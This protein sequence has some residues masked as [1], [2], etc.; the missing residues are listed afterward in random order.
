MCDME[1][2]GRLERSEKTIAILG[3]RW[4][5]WAFASWS[6]SIKQYF[7]VFLLNLF[8]DR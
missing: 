1:K 3:D 4:W 7:G 5:S 6:V 8:V 2:F